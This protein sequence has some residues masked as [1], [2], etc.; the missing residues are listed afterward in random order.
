VLTY[1]TKEI[2]YTN[3][4]STIL[5]QSHRVAANQVE[6]LLPKSTLTSSASVDKDHPDKL[7]ENA[8]KNTNNIKP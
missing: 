2:Y 4:S 6:V 7:L 1:C 3:H 5:D 8:L